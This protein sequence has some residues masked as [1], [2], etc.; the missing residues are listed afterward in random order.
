MR[1]HVIA[2]GKH[3]NY[4]I[5][6][7]LTDKTREESEYALNHGGIYLSDI[8]TQESGLDIEVKEDEKMEREMILDLNASEFMDLMN[9]GRISVR[10]ERLKY[11]GEDLSCANVKEK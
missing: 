1:V 8:N 6:K 11:N 2:S 5:K 10:S 4:T 9:T 7:I 3:P